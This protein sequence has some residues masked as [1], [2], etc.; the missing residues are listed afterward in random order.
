MGIR[1]KVVKRIERHFLVRR[2]VARMTDGAEGSRY[3]DSGYPGFARGTKHVPGT[4][5]VDVENFPLVAPNRRNHCR[6]MVD[7]PASPD[8]GGNGS[9]IAQIAIDA[10]EIQ[11]VKSWFIALLL[12]ELS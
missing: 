6:A 3:N 7:L 12:V 9:R 2:K 5:N 8:S 1:R 10:L 4:E 11:A